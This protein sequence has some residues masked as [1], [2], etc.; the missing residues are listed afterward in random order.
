MEADILEEKKSVENTEDISNQQKDTNKGIMENFEIKDKKMQKRFD[1]EMEKKFGK[2]PTQEDV[3]NHFKGTDKYK[4]MNYTQI[5][6]KL[7]AENTPMEERFQKNVKKNVNEPVKEEEK[8][9]KKEEKPSKEDKKQE[10]KKKKEEKN[11][12]DTE[13]EKEEK[14]KKEKKV[15]K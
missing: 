9:E 15:K 7:K 5:M 14:P 11:K 1:E 4:N 6:E 12:K 10:K 2:T 8:E 13:E 3:V